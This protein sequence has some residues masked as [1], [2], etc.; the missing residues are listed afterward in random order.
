LQNQQKFYLLVTLIFWCLIAFIVFFG[1]WLIN[2]YGLLLLVLLIWLVLI[3]TNYFLIDLYKMV[4]GLKITPI[5]YNLQVIIMLGLIYMQLLV[6]YFVYLVGNLNIF[7]ALFLV[8]ISFMFY[9][10]LK[11]TKL[12]AS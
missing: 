9:Y 3:L 11:S 6:A 5:Y 8:S 2:G 12:V 1:D 4:K 7:T 10:L